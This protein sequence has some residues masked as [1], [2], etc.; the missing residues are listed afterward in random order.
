LKFLKNNTGGMR[1]LIIEYTTYIDYDN[2]EVNVSD[3]NSTIFPYG[4]SSLADLNTLRQY[5]SSLQNTS[6]TEQN[7]L[8][9]HLCEKEF[10][11]VGLFLETLDTIASLFYCLE[12]QGMSGTPKSIDHATYN[13]QGVQAGLKTLAKLKVD[14]VSVVNAR[15]LRLSEMCQTVILLRTALHTYDVPGVRNAVK[16]LNLM[17]SRKGVFA[18]KGC[19]YLTYVTKEMN[20]AIDFCDRNEHMIALNRTLS[21]GSA[22][23]DGDYLDISTLNVK[24]LEEQIMKTKADSYYLLD[25]NIPILVDGAELVLSM[26]KLLKNE[27]W[28]RLTIIAKGYKRGTFEIKKVEM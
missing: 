20:Y 18:I 23:R 14:D 15:T 3:P 1:K 25:D 22:T 16:E 12:S 7:N 27:D 24:D 19:S 8:A 2:C 13:I 6:K 26:R 21:L 4:I 17:Y 9:L 10:L 5:L 11:M 28:G